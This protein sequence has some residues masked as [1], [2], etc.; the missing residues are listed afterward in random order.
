MGT[1]PL[2]QAPTRN[3]SGVGWTELAVHRV[4]TSGKGEGGFMF[5]ECW[6]LVRGGTPGLLVFRALWSLPTA[7]ELQLGDDG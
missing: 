1:C 7:A 3:C 4:Q 2:C 6:Y 5:W